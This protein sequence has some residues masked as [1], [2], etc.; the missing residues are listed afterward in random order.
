MKSKELEDAARDYLLAH[1]WE[2]DCRNDEDVIRAFK[3][4]AKWMMEQNRKLIEE[5]LLGLKAQAVCCDDPTDFDLATE[6]V[7]MI[8]EA[9]KIEE[10]G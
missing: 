4:C 5:T 2:T 1:I 8:A 7:E 9:I 6:V 10:G 3:A